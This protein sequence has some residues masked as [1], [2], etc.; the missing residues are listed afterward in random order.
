M[1]LAA[2]RAPLYKLQLATHVIICLLM[3]YLSHVVP[4]GAMRATHIVTAS[5]SGE[6]HQGCSGNWAKLAG[7]PLYGRQPVAAR[8]GGESSAPFRGWPAAARASVQG[9]GVV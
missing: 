9:G 8:P 1:P 6:L 5:A 3:R 2:V 4:H 7:A